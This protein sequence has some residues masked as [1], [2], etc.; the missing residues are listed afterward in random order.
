MDALYK[1]PLAE[2]IGARNKLTTLLKRGGNAN[3]ANLVKALAKPSISAWAVNQLYWEHREAFDGL[4]VT[5]DRF[6]QALTSDPAGRIADVR[7]SLDARREALSHLS[8]LAAA[9]LRDAG[10]NPTPDTI[11]HIITTLEA[12]SA[13]A[14]ISGGPTLGRLTQDVDPPSFESLASLIPST[15]TT[16]RKLTRTTPQQSG[17]T[18]AKA[19]QRASSAGEVQ[20]IQK[21]RQLEETRRARIAAA[22]VSSQE[23]KRSLTEARSSAQRLEAARKKAH[24][25]A[26]EADE[27]ARQAE[28]RLREAEER[29]KK[30]SA[31]SQDTAHRAQ[32]IA[33]NASRS[34]RRRPPRLWKTPS[35]LSKRHQKSSSYCFRNRQR[36]SR[37]A[38]E[39]FIS[40]EGEVSQPTY[41]VLAGTVTCSTIGVSTEK[42]MVET[43][44]S[45]VQTRTA[46][47]ET[48]TAMVETRTA[49]VETR[50][51]M[52][53]TRMSMVETRMSMVETR[54]SMV[55]TRMTM[56]ETRTTMVET[57]MLIV[58]I[59]CFA[60]HVP[61]RHRLVPTS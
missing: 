35:A 50:M 6:R 18:A 42:A 15:D 29:F 13:Y 49:M 61:Q 56:V 53:E 44:T 27:E 34:R 31:A 32:R 9:L 21:V 46:M 4:L 25:E 39:R 3:D 55:E 30:V 38:N 33:L 52:V 45:T 58:A 14:T 59:S 22:K 16:E 8:D 36:S 47:V 28:K 24:A 5:G 57:R 26:N 11:H 48:R 19:A 1:L 60:A 12:V 51:T 41:A 20:D 17:S 7:E 23:A 10:H 2:F 37:S 54:M 40:Y 43:R